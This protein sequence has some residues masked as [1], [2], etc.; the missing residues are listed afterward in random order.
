MI[1]EGGVE[2]GRKK[3]EE[4]GGGGVKMIEVVSPGDQEGQCVPREG[5]GEAN[6]R[7]LLERVVRAKPFYS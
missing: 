4:G 6:E 3:W 1:L 2:G 7:P 5:K